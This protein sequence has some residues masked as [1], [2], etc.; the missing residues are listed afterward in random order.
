MKGL[1]VDRTPWSPNLAYY[2]GHKDKAVQEKGQIAFLQE[3]G[4]DPLLRGANKLFDVVRNN[5]KITETVKGSELYITY[6]TRIGKITETNTYSTG[7]NTWFLTGHPVKTKD[8]FKILQYIYENTTFNESFD[9][10]MED[11]N[12]IG[13]DGLYLP[14]IGT[15]L[16]TSFQSLIEHWCGTEELTYSLCDFPE[17]VEE[18]L[19][20][21]RRKAVETVEISV[22]SPAE[23]FIFWEDSSTTNISPL[24][25]E[26]YTAPEIN[27]WGKIAHENDRLLVH[28]ACGHLKDLLPLMS[29][30]EIDVIESI[31]P[32]PTGNIELWDARK[33]LPDNIGLIG[34]IE[35]TIFLKSTMEEL[36]VYV[37][38]LLDT[39]K[40]TRYVLANSDSCPP[41][42]AA[43][44][45][46]L[47]ADIVRNYV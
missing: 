44:K 37:K 39:L 3:I 42:V 18:C 16:K 17:V 21:M 9:D 12:K 35:P 34:G 32:P 14:V 20:V 40:D 36:E 8:D 10:F 30:I 15:D 1:E 31:S 6:E 2:W 25:F 5:C 24:Y 11:Y 29:K 26:M 41:Y 7:G 38:Y 46:R 27:M 28:H 23:G 33:I 45:F 22:K 4:A 43:E 13:D 47:V 19:S